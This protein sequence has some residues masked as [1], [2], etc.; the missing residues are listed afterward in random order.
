M[1]RLSSFF[2]L[3][4]CAGALA[5]LV[6]HAMS[7]L[8]S[9]SELNVVPPTLYPHKVTFSNYVA[10]FVKHPF[11]RYCINS[12]VVSALTSLICVFIASLAAYQLARSRRAA[13]RLGLLVVGFFPPI[14]YVFA[15][16]EIIQSARTGQSFVGTHHPYTAANLPFAIWLLIGSFQQVPLELEEA[17]EID[18]LTRFQTYRRS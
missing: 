14:V 8:K 2:V 12:F 16:Y 9:S 6:W 17:A 1:K 7:S 13:I 4:C 5:P 11:V 3:V 15:D 10:L 18:G